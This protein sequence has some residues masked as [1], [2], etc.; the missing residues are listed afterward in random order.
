MRIVLAFLAL[1]A[2]GDSRELVLDGPAQVTV[3]KLGPV[4][5]PRVLLS[6]GTE[7]EGLVLT[8]TPEGVATVD[9]LAVTAA[10]PGTAAVDASWNGKHVVWNLV[11]DPRVTLR[12]VNPPAEL[13]V[14]ARQ[15][16]HVEARMGDLAVDPGE[17]VWSSSAPEVAEVDTAGVVVAKAPG[18]TYVIV[19]RGTSEAMAQV[20][21]V[22]AP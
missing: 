17:L 18:T 15:P 4:Q 10:A 12:L 20:A 6:D 5:G 2:C 19:K 14:G 22:P 8:V 13:A 16:M 21:V 11:V 7:P 3:D 9:G 1:A